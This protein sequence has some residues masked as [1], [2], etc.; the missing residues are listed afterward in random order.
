MA[1]NVAADDWAAVDFETSRYSMSC[2][3]MPKM[4]KMT[5]SKK[6]I[7]RQMSRAMVFLYSS[8]EALAF[9]SEYCRALLNMESVV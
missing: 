3:E 1:L 5:T 4:R 6:Q 9:R 2:D 8:V 7:L